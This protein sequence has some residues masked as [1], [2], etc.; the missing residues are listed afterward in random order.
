[1]LRVAGR[2]NLRR[3]RG[4]PFWIRNMTWFRAY[5]RST[6][7]QNYSREASGDARRK[8]GGRLPVSPFSRVLVLGP[9]LPLAS[10]ASRACSDAQQRF[11]AETFFPK[12]ARL[13]A[14]GECAAARASGTRR[15]PHGCGQRWMCV[16]PWASFI[17]CQ[18]ARCYCGSSLCCVAASASQRTHANEPGPHVRLSPS[19]GLGGG[20]LSA[21]R[22]SAGGAGSESLCTRFP[23]LLLSEVRF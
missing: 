17:K 19:G 7:R 11:A 8:S 12:S 1:M 18:A 20:G 10:A 23:T 16:S 22:V 14:D 6:G 2:G 3:R 13:C 15:F 5:T 4:M 9:P 21:R